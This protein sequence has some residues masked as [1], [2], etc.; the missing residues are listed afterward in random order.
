MAKS[1][2]KLTN[3]QECFCEEYLKD[4]NATQAA[5]RSGYSKKTAYSSGHRLLKKDDVAS[6]LNVIKKRKEKSEKLDRDWVTQRLQ[7]VAIRCLQE[8]QVISG[9]VATGEFKFDSSGA[10]KSL[11]LLGKTLG[12][13]VD[14]KTEITE[15]PTLSIKV[16]TDASSES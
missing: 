15:I 9:G 14:N 7:K 5:I 16:E 2:G 3:Q 10:N 6:Y 11:E 12:M 4:F 13:F 8:E 1:N